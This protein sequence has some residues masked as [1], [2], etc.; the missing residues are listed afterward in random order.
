MK[1]SNCS[2]ILGWPTYSSSRRGRSARSSASSL[3]EVL[4]A[5][6]HARAAA[7]AQNRRSGW[8]LGRWRIR[9]CGSGH[10]LP[11]ARVCGWTP[12]HARP[13]CR[14]NVTSLSAPHFDA[15]PTK[16]T[17]RWACAG[18]AIGL[19][20]CR[21]P[22]QMD[23]GHADPG[24]R[25]TVAAVAPSSRRPVRRRPTRRRAIGHRRQCAGGR[26]R[27]RPEQ[28]V[29]LTVAGGTSVA[30]TL[31][32]PAHCCERQRALLPVSRLPF[33]GRRGARRKSRPV[34]DAAAGSPTCPGRHDFGHGAPQASGGHG[35]HWA[36][37]ASAARRTGAS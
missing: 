13:P 12:C 30:A 16:A 14:Y 11:T 21:P 37:R 20:F 36:R 17:A 32:S 28:T 15:S 5:G 10:R 1:I 23:H 9:R 29:T 27:H 26:G 7:V 33:E 34:A 24:R 25:Q 31:L 8:S 19:S 22:D 2:R 18:L 4:A 6:H 35:G 3:G